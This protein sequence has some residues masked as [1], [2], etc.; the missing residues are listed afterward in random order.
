MNP[1]DVGEQRDDVALA[2]TT[3]APHALAQGLL[4]RSLRDARAK[5]FG[6]SPFPSNIGRFVVLEELGRGG[7]GTVYAVYDPKLDRK[8]ALKSLHDVTDPSDLLAEARALAQVRHPHVTTVFEA[9]ANDHGIHVTM[10]LVE[11]HSLSGW[12]KDEAPSFEDRLRVMLQ[13]GRGLAAVH[14]AGL[15]HRDVTPNNIMVD[16]S[17]DA[18]LVDFG[19]AVNAASGPTGASG[20]AGYIAPEVVEGG[21]TSA[22]SDQYA[23]CTVAAEALG[24]S[25]RHPHAPDWGPI[26]SAAVAVI[27]RGL[28]HDPRRRHES[29]VALVEALDRAVRIRTIR[30]RS[31]RQMLLGASVALLTMLC[32]LLGTAALSRWRD[33]RALS[34]CERD[35]QRAAALFWSPDRREGIHAA[36]E[37]HG[38]AFALT[39]TTHT[40]DAL[41][42]HVQA[43]TAAHT[44]ACTAEWSPQLQRRGRWCTDVVAVHTESLIN[45]LTSTDTHVAAASTEAVT[46]L[47]PAQDCANRSVLTRRPLPPPAETRASVLST[48]RALAE[49]ATMQRL[50][51]YETAT[52]LARAVVEQADATSWTPLSARARARLG[53]LLMIGGERGQAVQH[54]EAAYFAAQDAHAP[55]V[56]ASAALDLADCTGVR[57]GDHDDGERWLRHANVAIEAEGGI[58]ALRHSVDA[59]L[60]GGA[61]AGERGDSVQAEAMHVEAVRRA[62]HS[63]GA[64][65]LLLAR[66]LNDLGLLLVSNSKFAQ[67]ETA[68]LESRDIA[69]SQLSPQHPNLAAS[70]T[71]LSQL[72]MEEGQPLRALALIEEALELERDAYGDE[73]PQLLFGHNLRAILLDRLGR[74]EEALIARQHALA[75]VEADRDASP[76]DVVIVRSNYALTL[77]RLGRAED[78]AQQCKILIPAAEDAFGATHSQFGVLLNNCAKVHAEVG[79]PRTSVD[80]FSRALEIVRANQGAERAAATIASN[81]GEEL[82]KLGEHEA[83][84]RHLMQSTATLVALY[85]ETHPEVAIV[86]TKL[87]RALLAAGDDAAARRAFRDAVTIFDH[88]EGKYVSATIAREQLQRL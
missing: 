21:H 28:E 58:P 84:R 34:A 8:L 45:G 1:A 17:G 20:T 83:S 49:A 78:A 10:E 9:F 35:A 33:A 62:R 5:L 40:L 72:R 37:N 25:I 54:L 87:G 80:T 31:A 46:L 57:M 53:Q 77:A 32:L 79:D 3:S 39:A 18:Q 38:A 69:E 74:S 48:T 73:H 41:D 47:P 67:A 12:V 81:L 4:D 43:W 50:G 24:A 30:R 7:M 19:L 65:S 82:S 6:R 44:E 56:A 13:A 66:T 11:G 29:L 85:G 27:R 36:F 22:A 15:V 76:T 70:L 14:E 68:L 42:Q 2:L 51:D 61:I 23:F 71:A 26:P 75:V 16:R 55:G 59:L 63:L 86:K 52:K 64:Q 88:T 60:T